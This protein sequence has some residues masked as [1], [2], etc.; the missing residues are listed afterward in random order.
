[1]YAVCAVAAFLSTPLPATAQCTLP[2]IHEDGMSVDDGEITIAIHG[3]DTG[4]GE[5]ASAASFPQ[6]GDI[7]TAFD[8]AW[9]DCG[10]GGG[11]PDITVLNDGQSAD[12]IFKRLKKRVRSGEASACAVTEVNADGTGRVEIYDENKFGQACPVTNN[13]GRDKL[14]RHET[15]HVFGIDDAV[16]DCEGYL[17]NKNVDDDSPSKA[18]S[19]EC[20]RRDEVWDGDQ[21]P[22][23][24][25][26]GPPTPLVLDLNGDGISTTDVSFYPGY[27]DF[28]GDGKKELTGWLNEAGGDAFLWIDL[29]RN[30]VPTD[31]REL[32][33]DA[34]VLPDGTLARH[35]FQALAVYDDPRLGGND[36]GRITQRDRVW[37]HLKLWWDI[38][39][40]STASE[41]ETFGLDEQGVVGIS[42][43][44][45]K[46]PFADA[47]DNVHGL[48]GMFLFESASGLREV[49]RIEDI[50][51]KTA[52]TSLR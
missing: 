22:D 11:A 41:G 50:F 45:V 14:L 30:G 1:M 39:H 6:K 20:S 33:G 34:T 52:A 46:R 4:A 37:T 38:D 35:G 47:H 42:L 13:N 17:S 24:P 5:V 16:G 7:Q 3:P 15:P 18:N 51:F 10:G 27:F 40:S 44:F 25:C 23:P 43:R 49:R 12:I 21:D 29:D 19:A 26:C 36:D 48:L 28:N 8:E 31:G 32:F 9:S 2:L